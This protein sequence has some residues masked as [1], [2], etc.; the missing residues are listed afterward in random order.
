MASPDNSASNIGLNQRIA[1]R[2]SDPV[3]PGKVLSSQESD[4]AEIQD[5]PGFGVPLAPM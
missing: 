3:D 5:T 4:A 2:Q 1:K